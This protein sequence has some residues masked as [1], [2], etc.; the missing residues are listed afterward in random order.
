MDA[1]DHP[2]SVLAV[3]PLQEALP[4][5]VRSFSGALGIAGLC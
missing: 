3:I 4:S 2:G 5:T 1:R